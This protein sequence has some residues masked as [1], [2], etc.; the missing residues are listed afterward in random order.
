MYV[1]TCLQISNYIF[2]LWG[3][4]GQAGFDSGHVC[5]VNASALGT[6][7]LKSLVLPGIGAFTIVDGAA[8]TELDI[9]AKYD[10]L[11]TQQ[12]Y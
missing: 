3:E 8:I 12:K 6:E 11:F 10:T 7:I 9:E 1:L 4:H 5:L 2:R